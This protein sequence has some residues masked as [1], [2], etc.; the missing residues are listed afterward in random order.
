MPKLSPPYSASKNSFRPD[1]RLA[2]GDFRMWLVSANRFLSLSL[3]PKPGS[4]PKPV[5]LLARTPMPRGRDAS[6]WPLL[7]LSKRSKRLIASAILS[8]LEVWRGEG[9]L[10]KFAE[11]RAMTSTG[12]RQRG[13][14]CWPDWWTSMMG[15]DGACFGRRATALLRPLCCL[16]RWAANMRELRLLSVD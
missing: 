15:S 14:G 11:V 1:I 7:I 9:I 5:P 2:G 3:L 12:K 13:A 4:W 8:E 16:S 6:A 10:P